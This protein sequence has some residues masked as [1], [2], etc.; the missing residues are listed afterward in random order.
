MEHRCTSSARDSQASRVHGKPRK[1][2]PFAAPELKWKRFHWTRFGSV[3]LPAPQSTPGSHPQSD[4][5]ARNS[6]KPAGLLQKQVRPG[7]PDRPTGPA[8][9]GQ[10]KWVGFDRLPSLLD[11]RIGIGSRIGGMIRTGRPRSSR[12]LRVPGKFLFDAFVG[13]RLGKL[14]GHPNAVEDGNIV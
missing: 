1:P 9:P 8:P 13:A 6:R 7:R 10:M 11:G 12:M 14:M 4:R 5:R 3:Q 2:T